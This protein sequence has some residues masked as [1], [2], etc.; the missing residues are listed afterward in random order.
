MLV[1]L[2]KYY[3]DGQV[4]VYILNIKSWNKNSAALKKSACSMNSDIQCNFKNHCAVSINVYSLNSRVFCWRVYNNLA[5]YT[6]IFRWYFSHKFYIYQAKCRSKSFLLSLLLTSK[7][8]KTCTWNKANFPLPAELRSPVELHSP[9]D[10][11]SMMP[12]M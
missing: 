9:Q 1:T 2:Q 10:S 12:N 6:Q 4:D 3:I 5:I 11:K 8:T 7:W